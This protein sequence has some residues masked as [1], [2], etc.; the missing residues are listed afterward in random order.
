M[1]RYS[2]NFGNKLQMMVGI[3]IECGFIAV[4][5]DLIGGRMNE[6]Q[7]LRFHLAQQSN[8]CFRVNHIPMDL[9]HI[10]TETKRVVSSRHDKSSWA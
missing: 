8:K 4:E 6:K 5:S 1:A 9:R 2:L 10:G 3:G 7:N